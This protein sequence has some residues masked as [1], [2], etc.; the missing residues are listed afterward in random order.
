MVGCAV[1]KGVGVG[2][3][4]VWGGGGCVVWGGVVEV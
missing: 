3:D 1:V 2:C 4:A